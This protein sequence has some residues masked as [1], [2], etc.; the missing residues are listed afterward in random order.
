MPQYFKENGYLTLGA[1]KVFH[2]GIP[3]YDNRDDYPASWSE[4]IF[5]TPTTDIKNVSWWA[6]T[7]QELENITLRDVANTDHFVETIKNLNNQPFFSV[8][9]LHKPH[10]PWDA[11]KEFFDLYPSEEDIDLP[12]NP[13][14]PEDMPESAWTGFKNMLKFEDCSPEGSGIPNIGDANVTYPDSKERENING[15]VKNMYGLC[16]FTDK[17]VKKSLLCS[18]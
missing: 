13:Y 14:I 17:R 5:H 18:H 4:K 1:G 11:P 6:Y 12:Q 9:G 7:E 8:L 2:P 3:G 15:K 16:F 10:M